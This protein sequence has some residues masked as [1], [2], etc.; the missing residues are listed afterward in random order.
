MADKSCHFRLNQELCGSGVVGLNHAKL[1]LTTPLSYFHFSIVFSLVNH[2]VDKNVKTKHKERRSFQLGFVPD[3][4]VLT[5]TRLSL[6]L[7]AF[8]LR[9]SQALHL[10]LHT[11]LQEPI[12]GLDHILEQDCRRWSKNIEQ[13]ELIIPEEHY[14][15]L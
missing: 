7:L 1:A 10:S 15:L 5:M 11:C 4:M 3:S 6:V 8:V 9:H 13:E 14:G 12:A 2:F